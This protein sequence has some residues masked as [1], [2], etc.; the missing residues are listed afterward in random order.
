MAEPQLSFLA[1]ALPAPFSA[2]VIAIAPGGARSYVAA[3]WQDALVV[4]ERGE[5]E[6]CARDG[7]RWRFARGAVLTLAGLALEALRNPAAEP[8]LLTAVSRGEMNRAG[9]RSPSSA[10]VRTGKESLQMPHKI[11]P[12]LWFDTEAEE[13]ADFYVSVFPDSRIVNVA[14][15]TEAGPRP[16]GSVMV[17]QFELS[18][19]RFVAINGGPQFSFDEA[20]S[21]QVSCEDQREIDYYWERLCDGGEEGQCGWLKDRYG[22]SWQ[23]TPAHMG[24]FFG[25]PD[26]AR[27]ERAM[28]AMLAMHKIDI[29]A[30]R[31]AADGAPA[32]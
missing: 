18:G 9:R 5:L 23:I 29:D 28:R 2:R 30:I 4:V 10:Q 12:N 21:L 32:R 15:Y 20:I 8:L 25:G 3:D 14:R 19:Q 16:P 13:A 6:L 7:E 27:A 1:S 11:T 24:D 17:V 31:A 26:P 22:L